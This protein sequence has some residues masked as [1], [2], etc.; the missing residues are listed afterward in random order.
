MLRQGQ[1]A[2]L[3]DGLQAA[4]PVAAHAG[5]NH[6]HGQFAQLGR[7]AFEESIDGQA[8]SA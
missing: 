8:V 5:Q 1:A 2:R 4:R 3:L 7:Q 6:A